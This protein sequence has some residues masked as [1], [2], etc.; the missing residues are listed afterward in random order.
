VHHGL[1][2]YGVHVMEICICP[3]PGLCASLK[4]YSVPDLG[5]AY[6]LDLHDFGRC[7]WHWT[8]C[9]NMTYVRYMPRLV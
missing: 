9:A 8:M 3:W 5:Y 1:G 2:I 4:I 7:V 6:D